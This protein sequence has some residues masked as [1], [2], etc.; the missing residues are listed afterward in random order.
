MKDKI[1]KY[2]PMLY[3]YALHI[4]WKAKLR[5][6]NALKKTDSAEYPRLIADIYEEKIGKP[7]DLNNPTTYTQKVQWSK[8]YDASP[9]KSR[10]SDKYEVREWVKEK[11]G[12]KYLVPLLGVWDKF[13]DIDF[14]SLP[15]SFVLKTTHGSG[16]NIIVPDKNK[17]NR[18]TARLRINDWLKTDYA[19]CAGFEM[20]YSAIKPR[21][22]AE[23]YIKTESGDLCDYKFLCFGG[24]AYYVWVDVDRYGDHR[25]NIYDLAWNLQPFRQYYKNTDKEIPKPENLDE[26]TEIAEKLC[27][28]FSH[29]RV[30]LYNADGKIYFGEM[31]F[32]NGSGFERI[33]P[34]SA[35]EMLGSLWNIDTDKT[36]ES[37]AK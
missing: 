31:T 5:K 34:D 23:Q 3:E 9:E 16:T 21:I 8:L 32:T 28:G 11:I 29:V 10:L 36:A 20:H 30:D 33:I 35:D 14:S 13:D 27:E 7:L 18:R 17:F 6:I 12:E 25:R 37:G 24:K 15:E 1:K 2:F 26:M 19:Y 4:K 22:I